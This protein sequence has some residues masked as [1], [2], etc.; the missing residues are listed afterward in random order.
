MDFDYP[1]AIARIAKERGAQRFLLVSA[2][3]AD[4][5]SRVFYSRVKG[6][7][8]QAIA[9]LGIAQTWFFRPSLL[10]GVRRGGAA[11]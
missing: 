6:E 3:G 1:V 11:G 2:L 10:V 9:S 7:V 8:E 5:R 4:A